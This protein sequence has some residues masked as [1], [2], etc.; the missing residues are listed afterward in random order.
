MT[1]LFPIRRMRQFCSADVGQVQVLT[2]LALAV[3]MLMAALGVGVGI[4]RYEKQQKQE[5]ADAGAISGASV[6][7]YG[8]QVAIA[9]QDVGDG[10]LKVTYSYHISYQRHLENVGRT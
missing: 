9:A 3:L 10:S 7:I 1:S 2:A 8:R 6:L 5:A 4:L